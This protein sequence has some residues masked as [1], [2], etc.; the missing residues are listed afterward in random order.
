MSS[1]TCCYEDSEV[2]ASDLAMLDAPPEGQIAFSLSVED[3][4]NGKTFPWRQIMGAMKRLTP[5]M[6]MPVAGPA[7]DREMRRFWKAHGKS[8]SAFE[9]LAAAVATSDYIQAKNGHKGDEGRPFTWSW[10]FGRTD[11]NEHR[12]DKI[13][14][15]D[16]SNERMAWVLEKNQKATKPRQTKIANGFGKVVWVDLSEKLGDGSKRWETYGS[17]LADGTPIYF[18]QKG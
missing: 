5:H 9:R 12:C 6:R 16:Y 2:S 15:G 7:R 1:Q 8:I 10:V 14:A 11:S 4:P 3:E 13:L 17:V 18:D